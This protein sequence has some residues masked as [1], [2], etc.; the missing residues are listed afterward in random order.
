MILNVLNAIKTNVQCEKKYIGDVCCL[1]LS[2]EYFVGKNPVIMSRINILAVKIWFAH[3]CTVI[4][5]AINFSL[6]QQ[7]N[8]KSCKTIVHTAHANHAVCNNHFQNSPKKEKKW[9]GKQSVTIYYK[10][11]AAMLQFDL[12][13][14][15]VLVWHSMWTLFSFFKYLEQID[16]GR[17]VSQLISSHRS[18]F[19]I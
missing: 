15:F 4:M 12:F 5:W 2:G 17:I 11:H 13:I 3:K 9:E 14:S 6:Q 16:L 1:N 19:R 10:H 8:A 7:R 18:I